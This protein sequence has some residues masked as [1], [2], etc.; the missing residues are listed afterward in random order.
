MARNKGH[1][2]QLILIQVFAYRRQGTMSFCF[3]QLSLPRLIILETMFLKK[4]VIFKVCTLIFAQYALNIHYRVSLELHNYAF[5]N[6]FRNI[7]LVIFAFA[8]PGENPDRI[9][10]DLY[11]SLRTCQ[12]SLKIRIF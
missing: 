1:K 3:Y 7:H 10:E 11:R 5:A 8:Y 9:F 12:R 6:L 4:Q 2:I